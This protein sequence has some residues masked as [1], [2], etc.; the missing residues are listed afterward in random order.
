[1]RIY[2]LC[3]VP[4]AGKST[5]A[6]R[7]ALSYPALFYYANIASSPDFRKKPMAQ[8]VF[9]LY[10]GYG[11]GKNLI[12]EAVLSTRLSRD[13]FCTGLINKFGLISANLNIIHLKITAPETLSLRRKRSIDDYRLL[14]A[15]Y[16]L[17]SD[18]YK[19]SE[20]MYGSGQSID[21]LVHDM[22]STYFDK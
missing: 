14:I 6:N 11:G 4:G 10:E 15:N 20:Y 22:Y 19:F 2:V 17:G 1:M 8:I 18:L 16:E 9:E 12:T 13:N 7:L 21:E 3:G 5:I